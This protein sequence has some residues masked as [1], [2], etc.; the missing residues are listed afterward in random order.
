MHY[1]SADDAI[2]YE[3]GFRDIVQP[4]F[5]TQT[6]YR[7]SKLIYDQQNDLVTFEVKAYTQEQLD[8]RAEDALHSDE[9][10][11]SLQND[12]ANGQLMFQRFLEYLKRK[13]DKGEISGLEVKNSAQ[14]LYLPLL[15]LKDGQFLLAKIN[16]NGLVPPVNAKELAILNLAKQQVDDYLNT[17]NN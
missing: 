14:L 17:Q 11:T 16:L 2:H 1:A 8:Q 10:A 3:D 6:H 7:T 4:T 5:N 13:F 15:P 12:V 9:S